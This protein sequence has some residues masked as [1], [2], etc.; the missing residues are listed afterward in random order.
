MAYTRKACL[1]L[2]ALAAV[3]WVTSVTAPRS[4][5]A[6]SNLEELKQQR[7]EAAHRKRRIIYN[8]DGDDLT[9]FIRQ[10]KQVT[11]DEFLSLRTS[12]VAGTQVDTIFYCTGLCFG[13]LRYDSKLGDNI[14][15]TAP[16]AGTLPRDKT[17]EFLRKKMDAMKMM[18]VFCRNNKIEIFCSMRMNDTHDV[19]NK[20]LF[21]TLKKEHPEYLNGSP[22][23]PPKYGAWSAVNYALP[24]IRD[25]RVRMFQ[26]VCEN[27]DLDGI[28]MDYF[29]HP[30]FFKSHA[31]GAAVSQEERD[32]M[33]DMMRRIR[34]MTEDAGL[35]RGRP[36]LVAT[37][38]PDSVG[39]CEAIGLDVARWLEEGLVDILVPSGYFRLN[40]WETSVELG[41]KH[42]VPVYPSL[43]ESRMQCKWPDK[44]EAAKIRNSSACFR[45]R[46]VNGW[47]S[48]ADGIYMFNLFDPR[49][50]LWRELGDLKTMETM[51]K[52]YTT[53]AR[54]VAAIQG[55]GFGLPGGERFLNRLVFCPERPLKLVPG[56]PASVDVR[57]GQPV[58][59]NATSGLAPEV[60]L[61]LRFKDLVNTDELGMKING[62]SLAS[63]TR[64][65]AWLEYPIRP[66][67]VVKG[68]NRFEITLK[69]ESTAKP[70]VEDLLLWVRYGK[71]R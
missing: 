19:S 66:A 42:G 6:V 41:H 5:A 10:C 65:D 36:I 31:T 9:A 58:G 50:P 64:Q 70:V 67:L 57:V 43:D 63:S 37:R 8:N 47:D 16:D 25:L 29:R 28:E 7:K 1:W 45:A 12:P 49:S 48:G 35:K 51:D 61:R 53:G 38:V 44:N 23:K 17:E 30:V 14:V 55:R 62:Q 46:A 54:G 52:V 56:R 22:E 13:I 4:A 2:I 34:R 24:E 21:S 40:P 11:P 18:I 33:T 15:R 69:A 39:Y 71:M 60:T 20:R 3:V 32:M 27:Y 68:T 26:E 59:S